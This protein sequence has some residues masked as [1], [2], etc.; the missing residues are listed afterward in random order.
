[1]PLDENQY[2][3]YRYSIIVREIF[4]KL[5]ERDPHVRI[6][7]RHSC[8][9]TESPPLADQAEPAHGL[10]DPGTAGCQSDC[11]IPSHASAWCFTGR[12]QFEAVRGHAPDH[13]ARHL[14]C[15]GRVLRVDTAS[16]DRRNG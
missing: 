11:R 15:S 2:V 3:V 4:D 5:K 6:A 16:R 14:R 10:P 13:G 1:M 12:E 9:V 8:T 7:S